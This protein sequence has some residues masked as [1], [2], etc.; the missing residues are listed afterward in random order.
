MVEYQ[1]LPLKA[2]PVAS[3]GTLRSKLL[4][5]LGTKGRRF[6]VTPESNLLMQANNARWAVY[7]PRLDARIASATRGL[8]ART[9]VAIHNRC[10]R[11]AFVRVLEIARL[12]DCLKRGFARRTL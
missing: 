3:D 5:E 8:S 9:N 10:R 12:P 1:P 7:R 2:Q 11:R 6:R 4:E